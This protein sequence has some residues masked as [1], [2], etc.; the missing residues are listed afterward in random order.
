MEKVCLSNPGTQFTD[1]ETGFRIKLNEIKP[2]SEPIGKKTREWLNEGGLKFVKEKVAFAPPSPA[3][4]VA[5]EAAPPPPAVEEPKPLPRKVSRP[6]VK[7]KRK[8]VKVK[9]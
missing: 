2:L 7:P 5:K 4:G 9:R 3:Q 6:A 8:P 1:P